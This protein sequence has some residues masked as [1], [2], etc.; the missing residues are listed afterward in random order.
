LS[1]L[2]TSFGRHLRQSLSCPLGSEQRDALPLELLLGEPYQM[3]ERTISGVAQ[4]LDC[5]R[6]FSESYT[7]W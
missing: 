4:E 6:R 5:S 3:L 2:Q 7:T 1:D